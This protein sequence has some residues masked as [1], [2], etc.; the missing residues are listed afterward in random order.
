MAI[1]QC[2]LAITRA[3]TYTEY[4][5]APTGLLWGKREPQGAFEPEMGGV[6]NILFT[7]ANDFQCPDLVYA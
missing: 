3:H 7:E 2:F 1:W 5:E 4:P 6:E